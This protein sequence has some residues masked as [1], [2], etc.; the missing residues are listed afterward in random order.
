MLTRRRRDLTRRLK[1]L[2]DDLELLV[3]RPAPPPT[4]LHDLQALNPLTVLMDIHTHCLLQTKHSG[5]GGRPRRDTAY[6]IDVL[7]RMVSGRTT[8][9][10]LHELLAWNWKPEA[11]QAKLA[12]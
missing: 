10:R 4:G 3:L 11:A 7:E 1:A 6:L 5:K 8:N 9:D 12:A 2:D